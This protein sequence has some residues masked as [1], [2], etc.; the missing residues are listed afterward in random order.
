MWNPV[1]GFGGWR[2]GLAP[3]CALVHHIL[4]LDLARVPQEH[5]PLT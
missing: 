2:V 1:C 5:V 4:L 3:L